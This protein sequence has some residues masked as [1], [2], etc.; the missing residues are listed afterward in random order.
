MTAPTDPVASDSLAPVPEPGNTATG[1]TG[2]PSASVSVGRAA[3]P[4]LRLRITP[5]HV[6][7]Y[8]IIVFAAALFIYFT[9]ASPTFLTSNNLLNIVYQNATIGIAACAVTFTI[10]AGNF[11]LSLG[12]IFALS[13]VLGLAHRVLVMR[14]G[15][16]TREFSADPPMEAVMEAAFGL[17][18][19]TIA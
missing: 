13:E 5:Q 18:G 2:A 10:I 14:R 12:S 4:G 11:D 6:R 19:R 3:I 8:G 9:V 16:I 17:V 1:D 15:S 7:D